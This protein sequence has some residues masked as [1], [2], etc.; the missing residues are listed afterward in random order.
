MASV[1]SKCP[2]VLSSASLLAEGSPA[3]QD[4]LLVAP[5]VSGAAADRAGDAGE[6]HQPGGHA[7]D[8]HASSLALE[9]IRH[10]PPRAALPAA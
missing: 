8:A 10:R 1:E 5:F 2:L 9:G 3:V 6:R 4:V 7:D